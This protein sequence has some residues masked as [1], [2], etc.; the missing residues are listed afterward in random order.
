MLSEFEANYS[1]KSAFVAFGKYNTFGPR[2]DKFRVLF[3]QNAVGKLHCS[4]SLMCGFKTRRCPGDFGRTKGP[5]H[6]GSLSVP[7]V[8]DAFAKF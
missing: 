6:N 1:I 3:L 4:I 5:C 7:S 2:A 8:I